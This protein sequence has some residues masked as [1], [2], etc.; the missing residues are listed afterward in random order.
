MFYAEKKEG[1]SHFLGEKKVA[2]YL[3][4]ILLKYVK[5]VLNKRHC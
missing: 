3:C 1:D 4:K 5:P 2:K